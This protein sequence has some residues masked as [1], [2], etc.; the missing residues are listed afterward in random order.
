[1]RDGDVGLIVSSF[2]ERLDE[3]VER[4]VD[5][6]SQAVPSYA[7]AGDAYLEDVREAVRENVLTLS[8]TLSHQR[9]LTS[10]ELASIERVGARRAEA[11]IP[12]QDLLRAYRTVVRT[13]WDVLSEECRS[14]P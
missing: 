2:L 12:L 13:C 8:T 4:S 14:S 11:G 3:V 1:L 10:E 5:A 6:I 9:A 7:R